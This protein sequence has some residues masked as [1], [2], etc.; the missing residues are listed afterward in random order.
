M[1]ELSSHVMPFTGVLHSGGMNVMT[2][3]WI[4]ALIV[5]SIIVVGA[6]AGPVMAAAQGTGGVSAPAADNQ[7]TAAGP[8]GANGAAGTVYSNYVVG[9]YH[10]FYAYTMP[11]D[12]TPTQVCTVPSGYK[13]KIDDVIIGFYSSSGYTQATMFRGVG[14]N[15]YF[16]AMVLPAYGRFE[17]S[18]QNLV[19]NGGESLKVRTNYGNAPTYWTITAH[20][21]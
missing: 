18:Y 17:H 8:E 6:V 1:R 16:S 21:V 2:K 19:L 14:G 9:N 5:A 20:W 13:L 7:G 15:S 11:T 4:Y 10:Q 12:T 3:R